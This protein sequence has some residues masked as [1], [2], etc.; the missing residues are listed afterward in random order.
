MYEKRRFV[1]KKEAFISFKIFNEGS[2]DPR[3]PPPP[4]RTPLQGS[5]K[6]KNFVINIFTETRRISSVAKDIAIGAGGLGFDTR[7]G[8]IGYSV[9]VTLSLRRFFEDVLPMS[10]DTEMELA[11][12]YTLT[13]YTAS[14]LLLLKSDLLK[15]HCGLPENNHLIV[16]IGTKPH[17]F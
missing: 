10:L 14:I 8:Q 3:N 11:N 12:R 15:K 16:Y 2:F 5:T 13:R 7:A 4:V 6:L 1:P 9:T 17:F